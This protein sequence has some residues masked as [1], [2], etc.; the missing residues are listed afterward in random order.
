MKNRFSAL[1][2]ILTNILFSQ[3]KSCVIVD[4][5]NNLPIEYCNILILNKDKGNYS[6]HNGVF[7]YKDD[8]ADSLLISHLQYEDMVLSVRAIGDTIKLISINQL[9]EEVVV[10][11]SMDYKEW[12]KKRKDRHHLYIQPKT[13]FTVLIKNANTISKIRFPIQ[14]LGYLRNELISSSIFRLNFYYNIDNKVGDEINIGNILDVISESTE[15]IEFSLEEVKEVAKEG[16]FIGVEF[17]G[18]EDVDRNLLDEIQN[19]FIKLDFSS[20]KKSTTYYSNKFINNG[21]WSLL[22]KINDI[23]PF[24]LK[25]DL[26][27]IYIYK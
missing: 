7:T 22:K 27:L 25:S 3:N 10:K 4:K 24:E 15:F 5:S 20:T 16:M 2:F 8:K 12:S 21:N 14:Y 1:L 13:E 18:F 19:N 11:S 9:L 26:S 23:F 17:I 6:N